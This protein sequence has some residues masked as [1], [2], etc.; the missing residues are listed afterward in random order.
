MGLV[1]IKENTSIDD[2]NRWFDA[3]NEYI[4]FE[5]LYKSSFQVFAEGVA[6]GALRS[7]HVN[8]KTINIRFYKTP[9]IENSSLS[10]FQPILLTIFGL[11][12]LRLS[13]TI[14]DS[15]D[16]VIAVRSVIGSRIWKHVLKDQGRLGDGNLVYLVSRHSYEIPRCLRHKESSNAF[17]PFDYFK[18]NV[19]NL[20]LGLR[21]FGNKIGKDENLL[22]EWLYHIAENAI[23]HGSHTKEDDGYIEGFRGIILGKYFFNRVDD[24]T[25]LYDYPLI[26]KN[27]ISR[28]ITSGRCPEHHLTFNYATVIDLGEGIQNTLQQ[29]SNLDDF[30]VFC[31][32]FKDGVSRKT[33]VMNEK[34]GYGLGQAVV[35]A[36]KLNGLL[37]IASGNFETTADLSQSNQYDFKSQPLPFFSSPTLLKKRFG[38][39]ISILWLSE[40]QNTSGS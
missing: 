7:L 29:D 27:Y 22:I 35:V 16:N 34:T 38:T 8:R 13:K 21:G 14:F 26:I 4:T 10:S 28:L 15:Q 36:S 31:T 30:G 11:E 37:H 2:I 23:E 1:R 40:S 5:I 12:L 20:L 18:F 25:R 17:P 9:D 33:N 6:L 3:A 39:S 24:V 32:A 19:E